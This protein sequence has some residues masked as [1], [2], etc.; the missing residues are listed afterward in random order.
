MPCSLTYLGSLR[1]LDPVVID[2]FDFDRLQS[3]ACA[4]FAKKKKIENN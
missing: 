2:L 1:V 3:F 4:L